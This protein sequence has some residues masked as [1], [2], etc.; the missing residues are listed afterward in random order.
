MKEILWNLDFG[1][2]EYSGENEKTQNEK[3]ALKNDLLNVSTNTNE[4]IN[5]INQNREMITKLQ[6][7]NESLKKDSGE[8][9]EGLQQEV[10]SLKNQL[11]AATEEN[12][13]LKMDISKLKALEPKMEKLKQESETNFNK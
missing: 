9:N 10:V 8:K 6:S 4:F 12:N 2:G 5:Q 3:E 7:E 13:S 1:F 11:D